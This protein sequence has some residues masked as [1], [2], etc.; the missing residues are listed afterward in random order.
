ML[1]LMRGFM[2]STTGPNG[3]CNGS[4]KPQSSFAEAF[5]L[6]DA[7]SFA[8][9]DDLDFSFRPFFLAL[10]PVAT[11]GRRDETA[12][13]RAAIMSL[14]YWACPS[15]APFSIGPDE[16]LVTYLVV[17]RREFHELE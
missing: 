10:L 11:V 8:P 5:L 1:P 14:A 17:S 2:I 3:P 12:A 9:G 4:R 7:P 6:S 15:F 16:L 13:L